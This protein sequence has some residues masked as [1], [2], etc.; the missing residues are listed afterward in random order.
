MMRNFTLTAAL[1]MCA[2][3]TQ[4]QDTFSI[5]AVDTV[6]GEVGS[7]GASCIDQSAIAGGVKIISDVHPGVGVVHT[8]SYYD[9]DNQAYARS[10]MNMGL[11]P[12]QIIDSLVAHDVAEN[13]ERRQ[14]GVVDLANGGRSAAY[15]GVDC[16]NYKNHITGATY[17]IQ[18]NILLGQHILDSI[19][20]R[21]NRT[22]GSLACKLMAA[23]QGAN[24]PGADTRCLSLGISSKSAFI[25]VA[26]PTDPLNN[27]YL[28]LNVPSVVSGRDPIDSLQTLFNNAGG[29]AFFN[30]T[31]EVNAS[32][33]VSIRPHPVSAVSEMVIDTRVK[34]NDA[35]LV[36]YDLMGKEISQITNISSNRI[37]IDRGGIASGVYLFKLSAGSEVIAKGKL[38]FE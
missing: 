2:A 9:A 15:T 32:Y 17:A 19:E 20:V 31:C 12:Q 18:G 6:T 4:A 14:Y 25:R 23:L 33:Q 16:F 24:V 28:D 38:V 3:I 26:K 5:C 11:S 1:L 37:N 27:L 7:A 22:E 35:V 13:P 29:C 21:F 30:T 8:Q 36:I 10:L 34:L